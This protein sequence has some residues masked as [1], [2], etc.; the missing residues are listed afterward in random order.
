VQLGRASQ[1]GVLCRRFDHIFASQ[2]LRTVSCQ[3]LTALHEDGLSDHAP[4]EAV[5]EG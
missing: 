5:F 3:Y 2:G 1:G 4:I